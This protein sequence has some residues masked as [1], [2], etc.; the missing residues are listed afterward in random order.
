[1]GIFL[2]MGGNNHFEGTDQ[3][4]GTSRKPKAFGLF[5]NVGGGNTYAFKKISNA[6]LQYPQSPNE[7]SSAL[8]LQ[9]GPDN[10]YSTDVDT[11]VRGDGKEW[12]I[13]GHSLGV[14][15][16]ELDAVLAHFHTLPCISFPFD[17]IKGW[18]TNTA[19]RNLSR[20]SNPEQAQKLADE[21]ATAN[22]DRRRQ[23]YEALDLM[24]FKDRKLGFDLSSLL[25]HPTQIPE[26]AFNYAVMWALRNKDKVDLAEIKEALQTKAFDSDYA[27]KMAVALVGTFGAAQAAPLLTQIMLSDPSEE[28][29][30][31]AALGLAR[32]ASTESVEFLKQGIQSPSELVRYAIAIGLQESPD[33]SALSLVVPLFNDDSF[34]VRRAAG[35]TALSLGDKDGVTVVLETLQYETLDTGDNY[36]D[37]I[38]AQLKEYLGV[39]FGLD[40]QAWIDW[41]N[42][43]KETFKF[44]PRS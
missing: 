3:S 2:G 20:L 42:Q 29:R 8:F 39:D 10:S 28:I 12:G 34:Y 7:W 22:A 19:Y 37:N 5:L 9:I 27:R 23:I 26:D 6:N 24:R 1:V 32:N 41:W 33:P 11:F 40:R 31:H 36:G 38:Y 4:I 13:D 16:P 25:R 17:P 30:Y 44:P 35:L 43:S 21:I 14:S 15:I 18:A